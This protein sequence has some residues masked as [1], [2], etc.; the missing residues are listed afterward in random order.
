MV[1]PHLFVGGGLGEVNAS[2][3]VIVHER[4]PSTG[5]VERRP[6]DAWARF[7]RLFC[8]AGAG[9][10]FGVSESVAV[11][12]EVGAKVTFPE[13]ALVLSPAAGLSLGL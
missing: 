13:T 4:D 9:V 7:G 8:G 5:A 11:V 1:R 12:L 3:P 10:A 6:I 2:V